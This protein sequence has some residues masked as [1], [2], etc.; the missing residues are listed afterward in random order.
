MAILIP[1]AEKLRAGEENILLVHG[2]SHTEAA[3]F[4]GDVLK[5]VK[6][7][8]EA[9]VQEDDTKSSSKKIDSLIHPMQRGIQMDN[10]ASATLIDAAAKGR[11]RDK[12]FE[13]WRHMVRHGCRVDS[14]VTRSLLGGLVEQRDSIV[15]DIW[16]KCLE[17]EPSTSSSS[18]GAPEMESSSV[19]DNEEMGK[20]RDVHIIPDVAC[21]IAPL[22]RTSF[23]LSPCSNLAHLS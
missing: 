15:F 19:K 12:M 22:L 21:V 11:Q 8:I 10:V 16:D 13:T 2:Q 18:S 23:Y 5:L 4:M 17:L 20:E 14:I 6:N 1:F 9:E 3:Q 7:L